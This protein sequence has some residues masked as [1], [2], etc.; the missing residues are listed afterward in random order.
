MDKGTLY[1]STY[2][3]SDGSSALTRGIFDEADGSLAVNGRLEMPMPDCIFPLG[4]VLYVAHA[5]APVS[6]A[7]ENIQE[8]IDA[9][10]FGVAVVSKPEFAVT[11]EIALPIHNTCY[12][13]VSGDRIF[14]VDYWAGEVFCQR[15]GDFRVIKHSGHGPDSARQEGPHTHCAAILPDGH[16]LA[17]CDLGLDRVFIYPIDSVSGL[18]TPREV[19]CPPGSGPRHA[20][21]HNGCM[22]VACEMGSMVL[23]YSLD[24][25]RLLDA[26]STL[27]AGWT[28]ESAAA[29]IHISPDGTRLGVSNR[30]HDS[31]ALFDIA[32]DGALGV[33]AFAGT[34]H[35]PRD[36]AF[37][38][39]GRWI[40]AGSQTEQ[41]V[42]ATPVGGG[43]AR[44]ILPLRSAAM[45]F[46]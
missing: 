1:L 19:V 46:A 45:V 9:A 2:S 21:F 42:T 41:S 29:A 11:D 25:F 30:G 17:V 23:R 6:A 20:V 12:I 38:P 43:S 14:G 36:F 8:R 27:P 10:P 24:G 4:D 37:S 44:E 26:K 5:L 16:A 15:G 31:V 18:G 34:V 33:P 39:S 3:Y 22:Y 7:P 28:G 32:S 40:I 13:S 35:F